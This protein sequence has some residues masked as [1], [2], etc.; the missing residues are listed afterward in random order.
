MFSI[1]AGNLGFGFR[2]PLGVEGLNR[3]VILSD[4]HGPTCLDYFI[5]PIP[6]K[7]SELCR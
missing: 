4:S 5:W 1:I 7:I 6:D 3:V 2:K